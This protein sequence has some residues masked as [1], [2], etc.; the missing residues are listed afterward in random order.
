VL[1]WLLGNSLSNFKG[2]QKSKLSSYKNAQRIPKMTKGE[3]L[4]RSRCDACHSLGNENGIGPGLLNVT[5]R[6]DR[7]W[8]TRWL[9]TPDKLLADK[10]PIATA[11]FKQYKKV[12]MPNFRLSDADVEALLI[13][14][15]DNS[16]TVQAR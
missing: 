12:L 10:D 7:A 1:A 5:E 14:M 16:K 15:E 11:L 4:F 2:E 6:R 8:L 3:E 13:Y 9:K